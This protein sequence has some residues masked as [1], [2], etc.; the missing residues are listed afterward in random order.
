MPKRPPRFK[1]THKPARP[2]Q[3]DLR[4]SAAD[5]GYDHHHAAWRRQVL[6]NHPVCRRCEAGGRIIPSTIAHHVQPVTCHPELK[7]DITNGVGVCNAC[8]NTI[9]RVPGEVERFAQAWAAGP[10]K[11]THYETTAERRPSHHFETSD[12]GKAV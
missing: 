10:M 9:H 7:L 12:A 4:P 2:R 1:Y 3:P 8:H 5:R 6:L 11:G